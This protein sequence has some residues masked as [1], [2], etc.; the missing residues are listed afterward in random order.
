MHS[1]E[2]TAR[3][4]GVG[5]RFGGPLGIFYDAYPRNIPAPIALTEL[6]MHFDPLGSVSLPRVS[7]VA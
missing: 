4:I 2:I 5:A 3:V 7:C 1:R 6:D